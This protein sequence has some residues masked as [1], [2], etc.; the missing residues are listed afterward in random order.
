MKVWTAIVLCLGIVSALAVTCFA[1]EDDPVKVVNNLSI[2]CRL[3]S[4]VYDYALSHRSD[5]LS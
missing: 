2:F 5:G 1:A 3:G 4:W